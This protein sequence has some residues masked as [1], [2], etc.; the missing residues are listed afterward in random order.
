[1]T[2]DEA[3][4]IGFANLKGSRDKQLILTAQALRFL[5]SLPEFGSNAKVGKIFGVSGEIVREFLTLLQLPESIQQRLERK[6]LSLEQG[7]RL[8]QLA[9]QRPEVL[10]A[11]TEAMTDLSVVDGRYFVDYIL[12]H[13]E[14]SVPEAR[15]AF[16]EAKTVRQREYHVI[17]IL[18]PDEYRA[19]EGRA[20]HRQIA[21]NDLV[22]DLVKRWLRAD[23]E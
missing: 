18:S 3:I 4:A 9:R 5:K 14:L 16:L 2:R 21:V 11:A 12:R 23:D 22:T 15:A 1:M 17:A 8:W 19:L 7:R 20:R 13:P 6:E 10:L